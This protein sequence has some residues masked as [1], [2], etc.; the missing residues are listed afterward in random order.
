MLG[1]HLVAELR[2]KE[3]S[4]QYQQQRKEGPVLDYHRGVM[5]DQ[6]Q[7][8]DRQNVSENVYALF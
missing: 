5:K 1:L 7:K 3:K 4:M 2:G 6:K 8:E